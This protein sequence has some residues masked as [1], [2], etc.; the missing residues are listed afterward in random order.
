M[1]AFDVSSLRHDS[2]ALL[3]FV[4]TVLATCSFESDYPAYLQPSEDF[5]RCIRELGIATKTFLNAFP[6]SAPKDS[7]LHTDYRRKLTTLR[8]GWY[9]L[10]EYVKPAIEAHTLGIPTPFIDALLHRLS[11]L[12]GFADS[13]FA[14]IHTHEVMYYQLRASWIREKVQ[15]LAGLV[16]IASPFPPNLGIIALPYSQANALFLNCAIAH[17]MGHFAFQ[18]LQKRN[19]LSITVALAV[20]AQLGP[21]LTTTL[22]DD[23][24]WI[25]NTVLRWVEELFCDLFAI[26]LIGPC[27]SFSYIE[28]FDLGFALPATPGSTAFQF[29]TE[30]PANVIRL[31]QHQI[32]L[33]H[34]KWWRSF[35]PLDSQ[36]VFLLREC[37][38]LKKEDV[39]VVS[40]RATIIKEVARD[41][42]FKV[43]PAVHFDVNS[44]FSGVESGAE[45]FEDLS[46]ANAS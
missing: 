9:A 41:V 44:L 46:R 33:E 2:A 40:P 20:A 3:R 34:L 21:S 11:K 15:E 23:V 13:G 29:Y 1:T 17:E 37:A 6:A 35:E 45:E 28:M 18:K 25:V 7:A 22:V 14:L 19:L 5:F 26:W 31:Q 30:H 42:F 27:F 16:G 12:S 39:V 4:D 24:S 38:L 10:H 43:M 32:M 36:Y 8:Y